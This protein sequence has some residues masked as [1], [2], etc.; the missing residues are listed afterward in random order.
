MKRLQELLEATDPKKAIDDLGKVWNK[1]HLLA[2]QFEKVAQSI[3]KIKLDSAMEAPLLEDLTFA[4]SQVQGLQGRITD[5]RRELF[6]KNK[7]A[8]LKG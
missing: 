3:R 1:V 8:L 2:R 6:T 4:L 5:T 7:E